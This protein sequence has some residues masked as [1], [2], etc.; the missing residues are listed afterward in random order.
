MLSEVFAFALVMSIFEF[1]ILC[2]IAPRARL[3]LLGSPSLRQAMH[4]AFL[5]VNLIVHW[6]TVVGTMSSTLSFITSMGVVAFATQLFGY[7]EAGRY[8]HVGWVKY[9]LEEIK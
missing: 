8:Y 6:G 1:V 3:R 4:F 7:M 5:I 9:S 2:G